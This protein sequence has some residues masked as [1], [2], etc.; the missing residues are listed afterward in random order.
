MNV[1]I[2]SKSGTP[3]PKWMAGL[4]LVVGLLLAA[5][6]LRDFSF[7]KI[8]VGACCAYASGYRKKMYLDEEGIV[9]ESGSWFASR[10]DVFPWRE[11]AFVTLARRG[12]QLMAFF[13]RGEAGWKLLFDRDQQ[14]SLES[15]IRAKCPG[16][17]IDLV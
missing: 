3:F 9:R 2:S 10:R 11:V 14:E 1:L 6:A 13:E 7:H 4:A 8:L 5:D 17:E 12:R 16:V 15:L